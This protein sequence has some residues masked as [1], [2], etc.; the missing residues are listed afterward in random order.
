MNRLLNKITANYS[1]RRQLSVAFTIGILILALVSSLT[2]SWLGSQRTKDNIIEHGKQITQNLARQ[3]ILALLYAEGENAREAAQGALEFPDVLYVAIF[4]LQNNMLLKQGELNVSRSDYLLPENHNANL[5]EETSDFWRIASYV[6]TDAGGVD[7]DFLFVDVP[8]QQ[9]LGVVEVIIGKANMRKA[10]TSVFLV[11]IGISIT[12]ALMLLMVLRYFTRRLTHPL[13]NLSGIMGMAKQG[14]TNVRALHDGPQEISTMAHAF[15]NMM[16]ALEERDQQLREQNELLE[17]R[18]AERTTEL[19]I[20][21]D[22]ALRASQAKSAFLANMSHELR[23]PLNAIIGY[24]ELLEEDAKDDGLVHY[25]ADLQKIKSAGNHLLTLINNVLDLSK[26]EA[27]KMELD[28][29]EFSLSSLLEDIESFCLPLV[30]KNHNRFVLDCPDDIGLMKAD[31][32]KIRQSVLNLIS[33]AS[34]FTENGTITLKVRREVIDER[35]WVAYHISDTGIGMTPEQVDKIFREFTQADASTTRKYGGTGLGLAISKRF[36]EM[37]GGTIQVSSELNKGSIFSMRIPRVVT[38]PLPVTPVQARTFSERRTSVSNILV[39]DESHNTRQFIQDQLAQNG[40]AVMTAPSSGTALKI[41]EKLR[42]NAIVMNVQTANI[43]YIELIQKIN[44]IPDL[45]DVPLFLVSIA[46]DLAAGYALRV[47]RVVENPGNGGLAGLSDEFKGDSDQSI[48]VVENQQPTLDHI[49]SVFKD[50]A[51]HIQGVR[52]GDS[53]FSSV[54]KQKPHLM[55]VDPF[56]LD[57]AHNE[58]LMGIHK[59]RDM[60]ATPVV[61]IKSDG[62]DLT[63]FR[64]RLRAILKTAEYPSEEFIDNFTYQLAHSQRSSEM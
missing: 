25:C 62:L 10:V 5:V 17:Q 11:N 36:S 49:A 3:S 30:T 45:K 4:D 26:I 61:L 16:A 35:E 37:M 38:A 7:D 53:A 43:C 42:P 6:Y 32:M 12:L 55:I 63:A 58:F 59:D 27:G 2:T 15:N 18:V 1:F 46:D 14:Q 8:K 23:T 9:R 50:I 13:Y 48:L 31:V 60:N 52:D 64:D 20:A 33:N 22:D 54:Q 56:S 41:A 29:S 44:R 57:A 19:A 21:R 40:F 39:I 47:C 28:I 24:S 34:K 51:Q